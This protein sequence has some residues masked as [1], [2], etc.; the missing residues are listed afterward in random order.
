MKILSFF[1]GLVVASRS[2]VS[3][4]LITIMLSWGYWLTMLAKGLRVEPGSVA[5]FPG[6]L[7][8]M[9]AAL[10]VTALL[11]GRKGLRALFSR[12]FWLGPNWVFKLLLSLSPLV[13]G[14]LACL[15][16][17]VMG[18]AIPPLEA[19]ITVPGLP[20]NWP[21]ALLAVILVN[22]FGEETGWRGFLTEHLLT[23]YGRFRATLVVAVLWAFWHLPLFFL[24][25][26]MTQMVGPMMF[27]WFFLLVCGAFVLAF[28]YL[29]T[30]H[31]I[32]CVALWHVTFNMMVSGPE[33][34][35]FL[36]AVVSV[37]VVLS[38]CTIA[39][40]WWRTPVRVADVR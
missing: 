21:L 39:F 14:A 2:A 32:L 31:S 18:Q 10:I 3:F 35:G 22:G 27:G 25:T 8:P 26:S 20:L 6:L 16:M 23:N 34:T 33:G 4:Y 19:F 13:G 5:H 40:L 12:M 36:A 28:V 24:N 9:L 11:G 7:G 38:G 30:E 29:R 15:L 37:L 1:I 17:F